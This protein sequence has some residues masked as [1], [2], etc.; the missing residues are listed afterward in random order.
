M[1]KQIIDILGCMG[2]GPAGR[3]VRIVREYANAKLTGSR[4]LFSE[5]TAKW[6]SSV[7]TS[8]DFYETVE[9]KG[10]GRIG[11]A[12][13]LQESYPDSKEQQLYLCDCA[14]EILHLQ[15][16]LLEQVANHRFEDYVCLYCRG[17]DKIT[18]QPYYP[19]CLAKEVYKARAVKTA[20]IVAVSDSLF[21]LEEL[22]RVFAEHD[23]L[24]TKTIKS[25]GIKPIHLHSKRSDIDITK[26]CLIDACIM[27]QSKLL[28]Y[29]HSMMVNLA[30]LLNGKL[31]KVSVE[32]VVDP[33]LRGI[34]Q[35]ST[36][37]M[38]HLYRAVR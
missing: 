35:S 4:I 28:I 18:E 25:E 15:P 31:Q 27:A 2:L 12:L 34:L 13:L 33:R 30:V 23:L 22:A 21:C 26:D 10:S 6:W 5:A 19:P 20:Q 17:T 1:N 24:R 29:S 9:E 7:F 16:F 37:F 36:R 32:S 38:K 8:T 11:E 3:I 14:K